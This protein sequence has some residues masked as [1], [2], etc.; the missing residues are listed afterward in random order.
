MSEYKDD[1]AK[2]FTVA[3]P[4]IREKR[5]KSKRKERTFPTIGRWLN[6]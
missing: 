5:K 2:K 1:Y 6:K 3:L 4:V